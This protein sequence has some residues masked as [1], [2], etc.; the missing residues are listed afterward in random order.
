MPLGTHSAPTRAKKKSRVTPARPPSSTTSCRTQADDGVVVEP[1]VGNR[2]ERSLAALD[3]AMHLVWGPGAI[4]PDKLAEGAPSSSQLLW[5]LR[6]DFEKEEV[7]LP[8]PK[9]IKAKYLLRDRT[10]AKMSE[11]FRQGP[12]RTG[13]L[14]TVLQGRLRA[15]DFTLPPG[16]PLPASA[17]ARG[18]SQG[19]PTGLPRE[20]LKRLG[21]NS[22]TLWIGSGSKWGGHGGPA[23]LGRILG[24]F[25]LGQAP[26][27][28]A[29]GGQLQ[30]Y[31]RETAPLARQKLLGLDTHLPPRLSGGVFFV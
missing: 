1:R 2:V 8:E 29:M 5:G 30:G 21:K 24:R 15:R 22:G 10:P 26:N 14:C 12:S 25:G 27:G 28:A 23:C 11:S 20:R 7:V 4:N 17:G 13:G 16:V 6:V 19:L 18:S 31:R 3:A 9:R